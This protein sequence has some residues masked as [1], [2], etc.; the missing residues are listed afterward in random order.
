MQIPFREEA[1]SMCYERHLWHRRRKVEEKDELWQDF[2]Q[3]RLIA[4]LDA[5]PRTE[6]TEAEPAEARE[7]MTTSE[8]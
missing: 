3:T 2:D 5:E 1:S 4:D 7:E 6:V 8:R